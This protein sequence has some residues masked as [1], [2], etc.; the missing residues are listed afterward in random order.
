MELD[1]KLIK[2]IE[3]AQQL[4][5]EKKKTTSLMEQKELEYRM[6]KAREAINETWYVPFVRQREFLKPRKDEGK[7][8]ALEHFSMVRDYLPSDTVDIPAGLESAIRWFERRDVCGK[9][10]DERQSLEQYRSMLVSHCRNFSRNIHLAE[11]NKVMVGDYA[12]DDIDRLIQ[13]AEVL[14]ECTDKE[15]P[16]ALV[17]TYNSYLLCRLNRK[18]L[19]DIQPPS[20]LFMS[21]SEWKQV[22]E[23]LK[24]DSFL[25][26]L[27]EKIQQEADKYTLEEI[28]EA[29]E[30]IDKPDHYEKWNQEYVLWGHT[31][32]VVSFHTPV[33]TDTIKLEFVL[34]AIENEENGLGHVWIDNV[35]IFSPDGDDLKIYNNGFEEGKDK[36]AHWSFQ[37]RKGFPVIKVERESPYSG[38]ESNINPKA[39]SIYLSNPTDK[40]EA[41]I[42]YDDYIK[43]QEETNY[44]FWFQVKQDGK[45]KKGLEAYI[46]FYNRQGEKIGDFQYIYNRKNCIPTGTYNLKMQCD[47]ICYS[48]TGKKEY[49]QKAKYE[50]LHFMN[51]FCQGAEYWQIHRERPEGCDAFGAVQ[52]GRNLCSIAASYAMIREAGVFSEEEKDKFFQM[53]EYLLYDVGDL[54]DRLA[55]TM[56]QAQRNTGNWQTDMWAGAALLMMAVPDYPDRKYWILNAEKVLRSQL[57][58]N[59][60]PDGSWPE[61]LRYHHAALE[62]FAAFALAWKLET[63]DDWFSDTRLKEMFAYGIEV[64]TPPYLFFDNHV[65]TPPFGD[66]R[67]GYGEEYVAYGMYSRIIHAYDAE[68]GMKMQSVWHKAGK[69]V[70]GLWGENIV[71][72]SFLYQ[73]NKEKK[74]ELQLKSSALYPDS[75]IYLFRNQYGTEMENYLA[76]MA[77]PRKIG[78]GHFDQG[79]FIYYYHKVPIIMD[80][81]VEGY[82]DASTQWHLC[83][84]SHACMLFQRKKGIAKQG[85]GMI[86]LTAG[87]YTAQRGWVD[88]P[89]SSRVKQVGM[90][91]KTETMEIEIDNPEGEG[92][93]NRRLMVNHETEEILIQDTVSRYEGKVLFIL[94]LMAKNIE[95]SGKYLYVEGYYGV[96]IKVE[97]LSETESIMIE[98][99]RT[100]PVYPVNGQTCFLTYVRAVADAREGFEVKIKCREMR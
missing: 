74:G 88:V 85:E 50:I 82:F 63:G 53:I 40:D 26:S 52:A 81:G 58:I 25:Y 78:H 5:T 99:G 46:H 32:K 86:N 66:H 100:T 41:S 77:S 29:Y 84:Y 89:G 37:K 68:L 34:P 97:F 64:Q 43:V 48:V 38:E 96:E 2:D 8:Y 70:P 42:L 69:P 1:A 71:A 45:L 20:H 24:T 93:H 17:D 76:V 22:K 14:N 6:K 15:L 51:D 92:I 7:N 83:S 44:T 3:Q 55:M 49:A 33:N 21:D 23:R 19:S 4:L 56:E 30:S 39:Q 36:P 54:K 27:Y 87:T 65:A 60:N 62:R 94:P 28:K 80:S 31:E 11:E 16:E 61:S 98:K 18:H 73:N 35:K 13:K 91:Q 9:T 75:G 67:L 95:R 90:G 57:L 12:K 10:E 47:A 59:L 79:S 72:L